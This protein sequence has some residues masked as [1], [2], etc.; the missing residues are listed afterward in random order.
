MKRKV[1]RPAS[2]S[3]KRTIVTVE[4]EEPK[5]AKK[6]IPTKKPATKRH[7]RETNIHQAGGL[8]EGADFES[9]DPDEP[10][11]KS[12]D[13]SVGTGLKPG[14]PDVS[15]GDSSKNE[16]EAWGDSEY[17]RINEELYGDVNVRLIDVELE[18]E[19]KDDKEMTN[20]KTEDAGH[21]NV[22]QESA[23]NQVKDNAHATQKTKGPPSI[24]SDYTVKYLN[25]NNIPLS[26]LKDEDAMDEG[27]AD[28]LK[29]RKPDDADKD[30]GPSV[31]SD[32]G[33]KR[34]ETS[35]DTKQSKKEKS[36]ET[37]KDTSKGTSKS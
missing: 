23:C 8:S 24:S 35:K 4:E 33:L 32:Q 2:P 34:R 12:I 13:T 7:K 18:D 25:F 19:D 22:I 31:G 36:T 11:G 6:V 30:E 29:K 21:E 9:N 28:K 27:V 10:K 26:I 17:E 20:A 5:P 37:S 14:V 15:K 3:K 16:Y 1:K